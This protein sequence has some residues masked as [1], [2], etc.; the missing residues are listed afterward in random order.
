M[1][2]EFILSLIIAFVVFEFVFDKVLDFI[3]S[4]SWESEIPIEVE[5]LYDEKEYKKAKEY[6]KDNGKLGLLS[7][8]I[9]FAI[10]LS[11]L[12]F[13]GF[14][15]VDE[16]ARSFTDNNILVT[17]I[18]FGI[19]SL[20]SSVIG[21]PFS[22]YK[23]FV[24]EEKYGFNKT[25][26]GLFV[27][28]MIKGLIVS[29]IIGAILISALTFVFYK[30]PVNFWWIAWIIV[31][32]FSLFFA[33]FYTSLIVPIFNKLKPLEDG[34]LRSSIE[35][36]AKKVNFP[37]S[38]IMVIDGSKRSTKANAFFSGLGKQKSIVLYD[39]LLEEHSTEEITGI[40]AHEVGHYK[41]KHI[42]QSMIISIFQ[43]GVLFF[44]FG[45]IAQNEN[46]ALALGASQNAFHIALIGF[47]M[48]YSPVSLITGILMNMFSRKNEFE[49]DH[50]AKSTYAAEPLMSSLKKL[51]KKH[52]SNLTPNKIYSFVHFSHPP[53]VERLRA[54]KKK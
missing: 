5:G 2:P 33:T 53:V 45:W 3:N 47:S 14:G 9:S 23:T 52:L 48:L 35:A 29:G 8:L 21:L 43:M 11:M 30:L 18:F 16:L 39:T 15:Y 20:A 42:V 40:L 38:K 28:D 46:V 54:L 27:M 13:G 51:S 44:L 19:L 10:M 34:E 12:V 31:A 6:A 7:G 17:L 24:I 49:A 37:L 26:P 41:K 4:K 36:Y 22:I 25:G 50:Y 32:F 1:S